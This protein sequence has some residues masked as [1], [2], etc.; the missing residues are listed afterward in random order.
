MCACVCVCAVMPAMDVVSAIFIFDS[1]LADQCACHDDGRGTGV[2]DPA[3]HDRQAT[4]RPG[5]LSPSSHFIESI[6]RW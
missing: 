5:L 2:R 3:E 1:R 6:C 4:L